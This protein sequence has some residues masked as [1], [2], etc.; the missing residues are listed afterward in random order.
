MTKDPVDTKKVMEEIAEFVNGH[1]GF[2][3]IVA[4]PIRDEMLITFNNKQ[5]FVKFPEPVDIAHGVIAGV[6]IDSK[7][8]QSMGSFITG[9]SKGL[10]SKGENSYA[11]SNFIDAVGGSLEAVNKNKTNAK[12]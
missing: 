6:L 4:N 5:S 10:D 7:F 11:M 3:F 8:N 1:P 9:V 12:N 2:L